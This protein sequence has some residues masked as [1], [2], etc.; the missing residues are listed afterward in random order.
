MRASIVACVDAAPVLE[1]SEHDLDLVA[2]AIERRV[3]RD[4]DLAIG[5]GRD[6]D[7]DV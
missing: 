6:A 5:F 1:A 7:G 4:L 3:V 2:A